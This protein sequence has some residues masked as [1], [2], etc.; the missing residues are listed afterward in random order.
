MISEPVNL[1]SLLILSIFTAFFIAFPI[2]HFLYKFKITRRLDYDFTSVIEERKSKIGT[3]IMGGLIVVIS[4]VILNLIFNRDFDNG[5]SGSI[6]VPL[7]IFL[8][9]ALL[10]A[11]DDI[12]N[13]YGRP[14]KVIRLHRLIKLILVHKDFF[15]RV[16][17]LLTF[18]WMVYKRIF[19]VLGSN[20]G[21][22]IQAHE[23][24]VV[25][26]FLGGLLAYWLI[27]KTGWINPFDIW[28]PFA[29]WLYIGWFMLPLVVL[30]AISMTNAV[31]LSDGM[32]G[33]SAGLLLASFTGLLVIGIFE[34]TWPIVTLIVTVIGSLI[35]YLY[36]NIPP[37]RFQMGDVGSLSLGLLLCSVAFALRVSVLLLIISLPFIVEI[38]SALLQGM[39]R[40]IL[41]RRLLLMAPLHH[42]FEIKGWSEEKVVMRFWLFGII[43]A[44][45]GVWIYLI[46]T[47]S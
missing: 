4:V 18:P 1:T 26:A 8:I 28:I 40:R 21:K 27:M 31:N 38:L 15:K 37:A 13:I 22:G 3:P 16:Y 11:V 20:P 32:D 44:V 10:G 23:K 17:L 12:L 42:H 43:C 7:F 34:E 36:F 6:K 9:S 29:G 2:I 41:G 25:Q 14:R 33:L 5:V 19:F 24:V 47:A 45:F 46:S 30:S 39:S 35:T